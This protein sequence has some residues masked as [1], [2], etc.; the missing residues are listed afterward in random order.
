MLA[1]R[2]VPSAAACGSRSG[3]ARAAS[4]V[5]DWRAGRTVRVSASLRRPTPFG[6]PGAAG[7]DAGAREARHRARRVREERGA[8][9]RRR[10]RSR[11]GGG[12]GRRARLGPA[13]A[14]ALRR[15]WSAQSGAIAAAILI[16]DRSG[17]SDEDERRLQEAGTYH[18][19]AISGGNIAILTLMLLVGMRAV[20]VP[21]R[22]CVG[23]RDRGPAVLRPAGRR[24]RVGVEG[25]RGGVRVSR[26]AD[27]GSPRPGAERAGGGGDPRRRG[28]A[29][30][31]VRRRVHPLVRRDARDPA[32][33]LAARRPRADARAWRRRARGSSPGAPQRPPPGSLP[34]RCAPSWRS[35]RSARC[36]SRASR[37]RDWS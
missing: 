10:A 7:R 30:G 5:G 24:R 32:R 1:R 12:G 28:L 6:N 31:G 20:R 27:A 18:V 35:R 14:R 22:A 15:S 19:I 8:R 23:G 36:C 21:P 16:G 3:A 26:R 11:D 4:R 25:G 29:A 2:T 17:L 33:R 37:W 13:A 34:R 9:G